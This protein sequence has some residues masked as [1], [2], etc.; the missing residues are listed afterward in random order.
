MSQWIVVSDHRLTAL[1]DECIFLL[2]IGSFVKDV[3]DLFARFMKAI[4]EES[5]SSLFGFFFFFLIFA[6]L[7]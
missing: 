4:I 3:K 2:K 7:K 5:C 6:Q 1:I